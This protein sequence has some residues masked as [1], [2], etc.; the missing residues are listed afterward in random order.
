VRRQLNLSSLELR[1]RRIDLVWCYKI[2]FGVVD[3]PVHDLFEFTL[4]NH[5]RD[6]SFKLFKRRSNTCARSSPVSSISVC[7]KRMEFITS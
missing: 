6:H 7:S 1:R 3:M 4:V 2:L 5:T